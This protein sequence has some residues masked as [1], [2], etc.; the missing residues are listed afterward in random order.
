MKLD[1]SLYGWLLLSLASL[2]SFVV[3]VAAPVPGIDTT[4]MTREADI[5]V[6]ARVTGEYAA[7][8]SDKSRLVDLYVEHVIKG[9]AGVAGSVLQLQIAT[10]M[11]DLASIDKNSYGLF[12]INCSTRA[13]CVPVAASHPSLVALPG[14]MTAQFANHSSSIERVAHELVGVLMAADV[15]LAEP[16]T[17]LAPMAS[18][19]VSRRAQEV[20]SRAV[21]ALVWLPNDV[22]VPVLLDAINSEHVDT[23]ATRLAATAALVRLGEFSSLP[24]VEPQIVQVSAKWKPDVYLIANGMRSVQSPPETL[25]APMTKWLGSKDVEVRQA[26]AHVLSNIKSQ[27]T[28]V[29]LARIGLFDPDR[30]VRY[31]AVSGLVENAGRGKVPSIDYFKKAENQYL[32]IWRNWSNKKGLNNGL[33]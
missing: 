11:P 2:S 6:A 10:D 14:L 25:V 33:P 8:D 3:A 12:F 29:P 32:T 26:A 20:R 30:M 21:E 1:L 17:G 19:S 16:A 18:I 27:E 15:V 5:I 23:I 28:L 22:A 9:E 31:Y 24:F 7:K 4:R 13:Y